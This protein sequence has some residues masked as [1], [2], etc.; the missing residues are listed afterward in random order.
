MSMPDDTANL[1]LVSMGGTRGY[2]AP[3]MLSVKKGMT[4]G[5]MSEDLVSATSS[6]AL[7]MFSTGQLLLVSL[8]G[9]FAGSTY[10]ETFLVDKLLF[11]K[12][13]GYALRRRAQLSAPGRALIKS[14]TEPKPAQRLTAADALASEWLR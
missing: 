7:D 9:V 2:M 14:L 4:L 11:F 8:T 6:P 10:F 3:E 1:L 5:A 12:C 13:G